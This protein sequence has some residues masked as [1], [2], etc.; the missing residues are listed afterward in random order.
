MQ[1]A[2]PTEMESEHLTP[3][4]L[5]LS[6]VEEELT[7]KKCK[8]LQHPT[9]TTAIHIIA[10]ALHRSP[11]HRSAHTSYY[12]T[13]HCRST[14]HTP[15]IVTPRTTVRWR[16]TLNGRLVFQTGFDSVTANKVVFDG[17]DGYE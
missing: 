11:P 17:D 5:R 15:R 4:K 14:H 2:P 8:S 6:R 13:H 9:S 7:K 1:A 3:P 10:H 16:K 12:R